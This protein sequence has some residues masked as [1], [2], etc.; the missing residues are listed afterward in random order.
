MRKHPNAQALLN[1]VETLLPLIRA[2]APTAERQGHLTD[3]VLAALFK[4]RLFRLF[5]P[6][7]YQGE[8]TDLPTA[9]K[10]FERIAY[11]DG[12]TGWLVMIGAGGGLFSGFMAEAA[13]REIFE[14]ENAVIAGSG[15]PSGLAKTTKDGLKPPAVGLMPAVH[16]MPVGSPPIAKWTTPKTFSPLPFPPPKSRCIRLGRPSA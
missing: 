5:I 9:L 8:A 10:V 4:Q 7:C 3:A 2:D 13:A 11:A 1:Q 12:A 14:P 6:E 16:I 15:M